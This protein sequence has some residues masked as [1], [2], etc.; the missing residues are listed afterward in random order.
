MA[1]R[2]SPRAHARPRAQSGAY[3]VATLPRGFSPAALAEAFGEAGAPPAGPELAIH[4]PTRSGSAT[5]LQPQPAAAAPPLPAPPRSAPVSPRAAAGEAD[6]A[7]S[8][9]AATRESV[10]VAV[11]CR[12]FLRSEGD[13]GASVVAVDE[14]AGAVTLECGGQR[15]FA[16]DRVFGERSS[17]QQVFEFVAP[18]VDAALEGLNG[19]VLAYGQTSSGKTHTMMG[20]ADEPEQQGV[21]PNMVD[22]LFARM[23]ETAVSCSFL[24][25]LAYLEIY[26][27]HVRDLLARDPTRSL[28]VRQAL[29]GS[30][31]VPD[32]SQHA[33]KG[34]ADLL[35]LIERGGANRAVAATSQNDESSRSHSI[36]TIFVE[37]SCTV[38]GAT[39]NVAAKLNLV[40]LVRRRAPAAAAPSPP[41]TLRAR[42]LAASDCKTRARRR[43]RRRWRSTRVC[44]ASP[45]SSAPSPR[46]G[47]PCSCPTATQSSR[48]CS[49]TRSAATQRWRGGGEWRR[50][51]RG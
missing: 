37:R 41:L 17:Q 43:A 23:A 5:S 42:R 19:T 29:D 34:R 33:V 21:I 8:V 35:R 47:P 18:M 25:R 10:A 20:R 22:R 44:A 7:R 45:K 15:A 39:R 14:A 27:E 9:R 12:P 46:S 6:A 11:R 24:V 13:G 26:N 4:A 30:F 3:G 31:F 51:V 40:D 28:D 38:G 48:A 1:L 2:A 49:R 16:F 36:L 50:R 32:L